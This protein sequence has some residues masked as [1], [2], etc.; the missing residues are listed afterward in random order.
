MSNG[1]SIA[2]QLSMDA[3]MSRA[4]DY[5]PDCQCQR[6]L[7]HLHDCSMCRG[8]ELKPGCQTDPDFGC[9]GKEKARRHRLAPPCRLCGE[10]TRIVFN[11]RLVAVPICQSCASAITRQ[12]VASRLDAETNAEDETVPLEIV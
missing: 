8:C 1:P 11:I 3:N 4:N 12:E 5:G 10:P 2:M 9:Q 7:D 6:C